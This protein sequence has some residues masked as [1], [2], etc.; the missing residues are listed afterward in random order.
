MV[1]DLVLGPHLAVGGWVRSG[2]NGPYWMRGSRGRP[3]GYRNHSLSEL[4]ILSMF[5]IQ[6][7][8]VAQINQ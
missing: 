4:T 3:E 6:K 7:R 1:R 8:L 2:D 5:G